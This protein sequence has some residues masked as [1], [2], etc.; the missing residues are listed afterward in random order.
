MSKMGRWVLDQQQKE[1]DN[2]NKHR[3]VKGVDSIESQIT[4]EQNKF[5]Y[6]HLGELVHKY[7]KLIP[8]D[9]ELG[10]KV[11]EECISLFQVFEKND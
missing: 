4:P 8:N 11:R 1:I 3:Q 10:K 6:C 2:L 7:A 5:L 9:Q